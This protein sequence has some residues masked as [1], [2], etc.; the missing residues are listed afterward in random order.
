MVLPWPRREPLFAVRKHFDF[1]PLALTSKLLYIC[2]NALEMGLL[3]IQT[4]F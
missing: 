3:W 1:E 2:L 4:L